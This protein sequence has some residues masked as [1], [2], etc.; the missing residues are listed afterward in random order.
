M[1]ELEMHLNSALEGAARAKACLINMEQE[2]EMLRVLLTGC[3]RELCK[4]CMEHRIIHEC[5]K[6]TWK[7]IQYGDFS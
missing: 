2:N 3:S 5:D 6:C 7:D 1:S 4:L